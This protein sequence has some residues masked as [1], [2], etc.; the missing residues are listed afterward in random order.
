MKGSIFSK[1]WSED[2]FGNWGGKLG[3]VARNESGERS[4]NQK[5]KGLIS[6]GREQQ[7]AMEGLYVRG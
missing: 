1:A 5:L 4:K 3:I 6:H 2:R 7:A